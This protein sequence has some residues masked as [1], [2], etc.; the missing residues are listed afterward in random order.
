MSNIKTTNFRKEETRGAKAEFLKYP[1]EAW[2][3]LQSLFK[4]Q[5]IN[6]HTLHF[7]ASFSRELNLSLLQ[8]SVALSADAYPLI[9]CRFVSKG[10]RPRWEE[11]Y[12]PAGAMVLFSET[13]NAAENI[14]KFLGASLDETVG[15]QVQFGLF[16]QN[17]RD[18]LAVLMNH[19]LCD[20]AGFKEYLYLLCDIYTNLE[21]GTAM[22]S[23]VSGSRRIGQ[24]FRAFSI[25]GRVKIL[26]SKNDI[27]THDPAR[28]E[29][30]GDLANPF[31]ER[32]TIPREAFIS[33]KT[34]AK[35]HHATVNDLILTAYIRTLNHLF[36]RPIA[37][38]CTVD[39]RKYLPDRKA[40]GLCNLSTNLTCDIG[41]ELGTSFGQTLDRVKQ[42]MARE[43]NS[44]A[45]VKSLILLEKIFDIL[46]YK[47]AK[48]ILNKSFSNAPIALTNIGILDS[49]RLSFGT[50]VITEAYMTGSIKYSPYFQMAISTFD[51]QATLSVNLYGTS[52]DRKII[53]DFLDDV[54]LELQM[55]G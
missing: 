12:Y 47:T 16:R 4:E 1:V 30:E 26:T 52:F 50:S 9:R 40:E 37:I 36:G 19:M 24:L 7:V 54:M 28:F 41:K 29:L 25:R 38:P 51:N 11:A 34:Y 39:L 21:N 2:D 55:I 22:Y 43:K 10:G 31:I 49:A 13:E 20:A 45:C 15:P 33:L 35:S 48:S 46:P 27:S 44:T 6:D 32:R 14:E 8:R 23:P 18:T 53:S 17:G 3:I 5:K 42:A